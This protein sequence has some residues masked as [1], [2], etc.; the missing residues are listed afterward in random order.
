VFV[1]VIILNRISRLRTSG[2]GSYRYG[3]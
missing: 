2:Y 3:F 1:C